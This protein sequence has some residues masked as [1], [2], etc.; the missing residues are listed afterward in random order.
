MKLQ[1]GYH[2]YFIRFGLTMGPWFISL[3]FGFWVI[4]LTYYTKEERAWFK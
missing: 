3:D 4:E 1:F 2:R